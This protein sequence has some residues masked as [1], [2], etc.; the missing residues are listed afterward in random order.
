MARA[1]RA[2]KQ[3]GGGFIVQLAPDGTISFVPA[4]GE[5]PESGVKGK[6]RDDYVL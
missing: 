3:V 2:V 5:T 1:M 6:K 4:H